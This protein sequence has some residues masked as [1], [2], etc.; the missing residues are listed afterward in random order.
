M[1]RY[2]VQN[3]HQ[4]VILSKDDVFH[5]TK[6][7]RAK[8]GEEIEIVSPESKLY[9]ARVENLSPLEI[10]IVAPLIRDTELKN[11]ITLLYV[12]AKGE[13]T[14]L[15]I[16]KATELGVHRI[17][18]LTSKRS[19]VKVEADK[20]EAKVARF[21]K[22]AKEAAEQSKRLI[23]PE[24]M[25]LPKF[26]S[27]EAINADI[28]LIADEEETNKKT[29]LYT[30]LSEAGNEKSFALL[31]GPEGGFDRD[32]VDYVKRIGYTPLSLGKRILRSE[33]AAIHMVG[34]IASFLERI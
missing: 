15:V 22:I 28:K 11:H 5:L 12:M 32:E 7:M 27:L 19:V 21:I 14:D 30:I 6:V 31:V 4:D 16:Q 25:I 18:L 34:I 23:I 24:I 26:A 20:I 33:T 1:Q 17:I 13:K 9:L 10:R 2:F 3:N 29:P 8:K